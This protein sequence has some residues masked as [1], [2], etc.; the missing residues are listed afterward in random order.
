MQERVPK[1]RVFFNSAIYSIDYVIKNRVKYYYSSI[2]NALHDFS[3][4]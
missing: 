1:R 4:I 2:T 3:R